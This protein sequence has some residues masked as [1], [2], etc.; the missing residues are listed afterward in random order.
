MKARNR[1]VKSGF[2]RR[3]AAQLEVLL[4]QTPYVKNALS[5]RQSLPVDEVVVVGLGV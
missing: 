2:I 1:S 3:I 5:R 4:T